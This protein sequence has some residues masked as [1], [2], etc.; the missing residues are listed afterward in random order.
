MDDYNIQYDSDTKPIDIDTD[1][2]SVGIELLADPSKN[3]VIDSP[4]INSPNIDSTNSNNDDELNL[5]S[6]KPNI[7]HEEL[8]KEKL[9]P[10]PIISDANINTEQ[11]TNRNKEIPIHLMTP[12]DIKNE[13]TELIYK[14]KRLDSQGIRTTMNYNMNSQLED[15]RNEY[16]KLKKQREVENSIK[17]QRL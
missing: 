5:F 4:N 9:N 2:N 11:K 14:F 16:M 7:S 15:M 1:I 13:K 8:N 12:K 17:F 10:D 6:N 3:K